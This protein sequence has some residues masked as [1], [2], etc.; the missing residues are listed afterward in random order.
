MATAFINLG[1]EDPARSRSFFESLGFSFNE[2]YSSE[3]AVCMILN[4]AAYVMM[5]GSE[6]FANFTLNGI[7]DTSTNTEVLIGVSCDSREAVESL[8]EG[9]IAAGGRP[10]MAPQDHGFMFGWSFYDL[11]GHHWEP[12]WM[13][14]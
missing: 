9:A 1:V 3:A 5:L 8:V 13:E 11:D 14:A 10:A 2:Q 12:I 7:C 4:D 6:H